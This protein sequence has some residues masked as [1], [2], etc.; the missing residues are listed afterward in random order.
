MIPP[1]LPQHC[2][3]AIERHKRLLEEAE[4]NRMLKDTNRTTGEH[5][6]RWRRVRFRIGDLLISMGQ[7]LKADAAWG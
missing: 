4:R 6:I 3:L 5:P 1:E 2:V 7:R